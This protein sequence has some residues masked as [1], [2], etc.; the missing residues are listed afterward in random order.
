MSFHDSWVMAPTLSTRRAR[1]E[2]AA[3]HWATNEGHSWSAFGPR[4]AA[5][6]YKIAKDDDRRYPL[7]A[8]GF[9]LI[10]LPWRTP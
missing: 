3:G 5:K 1:C 9:W 4:E 10:R 7:S 6:W 2:Q 8:K